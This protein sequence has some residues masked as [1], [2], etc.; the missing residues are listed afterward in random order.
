[1][2]HFM[3]QHLTNVA[4]GVLHHQ[5]SAQCYFSFFRRPAS[6]TIY[7][8]FQHKQRFLHTISKRPW[9]FITLKLPLASQPIQNASF[10]T[11]FK[12]VIIASQSLSNS[13]INSVRCFVKVRIL[14]LSRSELLYSIDMWFINRDS[15]SIA[16]SQTNR[17][18][19]TFG[20]LFSP[21]F[22]QNGQH[23]IYRLIQ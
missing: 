8:I 18:P 11:F 5:T 9:Y 12:P 22:R 15:F 23:E 13:S 1:M 17:C 6:E 3:P 14:G 7:E 2:R 20:H 4:P 10:P 16:H 21:I 19:W